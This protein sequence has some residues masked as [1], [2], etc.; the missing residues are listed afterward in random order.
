M[1]MTH[2]HMQAW[3]VG[4]RCGALSERLAARMH[5]CRAQQQVLGR[6]TAQTQLRSHHQPGPLCVRAPRK[7]DDLGRVPGQV[8]HGRVDL[9]QGDFDRRI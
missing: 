6:V 8:P 7:F 9:R 1:R 3:Q 2:H 4:Q 5:E